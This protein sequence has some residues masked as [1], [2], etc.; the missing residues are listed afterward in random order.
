[1]HF[2]NF[3]D[4]LKYVREINNLTKKELSS[5]SGVT[6][7]TLHMYEKNIGNPSLDVLTL[8]SDVL[9]VDLLSY[10]YK[11]YKTGLITDQNLYKQ[12]KDIYN[13]RNKHSII[14]CSDFIDEHFPS[15]ELYDSVGTD[16]C[17]FIYYC[18]SLYA[19]YVNNDLDQSMQY[20]ITALE[21]ANI[22]NFNTNKAVFNDNLLT[23]NTYA[24]L[25]KL[26]TL[27]AYIN[28][29]TAA[30][31]ILDYMSH[32]I[33]K[34]VIYNSTFEEHDISKYILIYITSLH[35]KVKI[36]IYSLNDKNYTYHNELID[37]ALDYN[38][39][40]GKIEF[41]D[42]LL[43]LKFQIACLQEDFDLAKSI[44]LKTLICCEETSNYSIIFELRDKHSDFYKKIL[45]FSKDD[46][47]INRII[48]LIDNIDFDKST[49]L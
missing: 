34:Y 10:Y 16:F 30:I 11:N 36:S 32:N 1:M 49:Q 3:G 9:K 4:Y 27:Y 37:E 5:L 29:F 8:L 45:N 31:E 38:N 22:F 24:I 21:K 40:Y 23:Q 35:N 25:G 15:E 14:Q 7:K 28:N 42:F 13:T 2:D 41:K 39:K 46:N 43:T 33:K 18:K 19:H 26:S 44:F 6:T 47:E 48:S 12:L 17:L 20:C